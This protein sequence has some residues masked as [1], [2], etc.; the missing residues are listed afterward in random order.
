M[1]HQKVLVPESHHQTADGQQQKSAPP[2]QRG[3]QKKVQ[4]QHQQPALGLLRGEQAG[5]IT[6]QA[7]VHQPGRQQNPQDKA[8]PAHGRGSLLFAV[9][10]GAGFPNGLTKVQPVQRRNQKKAG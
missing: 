2:L 5:R 8:E 6:L 3:A 10:G 7:R 9:P 4:K 1:D